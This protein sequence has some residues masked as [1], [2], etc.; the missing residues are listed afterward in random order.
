LDPEFDIPSHRRIQCSVVKE[1]DFVVCLW[2][3]KTV[4]YAYS[5]LILASVRRIRNALQQ[6]CSCLAVQHLLAMKFW[7]TV[8]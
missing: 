6:G 1:G 3:L 7:K 5:V 4:S 8:H 2:T